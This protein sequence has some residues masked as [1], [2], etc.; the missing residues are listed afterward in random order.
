MGGDR[1]SDE[2]DSIKPE[3]KTMVIGFLVDM[4]AN[5]SVTPA[6]TSDGYGCIRGADRSEHGGAVP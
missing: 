3:T 1:Q 4:I 6:I 2:I 5:I